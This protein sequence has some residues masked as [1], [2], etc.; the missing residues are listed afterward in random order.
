MV[1]L[2]RITDHTFPLNF[3]DGK[4]LEWELELLKNEI[5]RQKKQLEKHSFASHRWKEAKPQLIRE[6]NGRCAYCEVRFNAVAYGDVEH[7]RPKKNYWWLAYS[8]DNYLPSCQLCNQKFKKDKF[9]VKY[10]ALTPPKI[11]KNYT[12]AKL[13]TLAG[14]ITPNPIDIDSGYSY[15]LFYKDYFKERPYCINPYYED[16]ALYFSYKF[17][18]IS[19]EVEI[20]PKKR[21]LKKY[22]DEAHNVYGLNRKELKVMRY[23]TFFDYR[24]A[25]AI[26]QSNSAEDTL[27]LMA[28]QAIQMLL[29]GSGGFIGM[30]LFFEKQD[31]DV[32]KIAD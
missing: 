17:D 14:K 9:P 12:S 7:Y 31:W 24:L 3:H 8:Y 22:V 21:S 27:V 1:K 20:V 5:L 10:K 29:N 13:K 28:K 23:K 6:T 11:S 30:I 19:R 26:L 15:D 18:D 4:R 32:I 16:P 2:E 25:R